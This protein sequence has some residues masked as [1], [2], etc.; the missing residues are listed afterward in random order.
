MKSTTLILLFSILSKI[1]F[2]QINSSSFAPKVDYASGVGTSNPAGV[3][4]VDLDNDGKNDVVSAN[5]GIGSISVYRNT[6]TSTTISL[7]A[8]A[9]YNTLSSTAFIHPADLDGDGKIDLVIS[10]NAGTAFSYFKNTTTTVGTITFANRQDVSALSFTNDFSIADVDGDLKIDLICSNYNSNSFSVFRNTSISGTVSFATRVDFACGSNPSSITVFDADGDTK[11]DVAITNYTSS[12]VSVYRNTTTSIG[13]P[14]FSSSGV[15]VGTGNYPAFIANADLDGDGKM[16]MVT[17]NFVSNNISVIKNTSSTV[18]SIT[19]QASINISSGSGTS[20]PQ[21]ISLTDFDNDRKIDIGVCNSANNNISVFKNISTIGVVSTSSFASQVNFSLNSNPLYIFA[22][23]LNGDG[24]PEILV[25]NYSSNNISILRNQ[26]IATEPTVSASNLVFSNSTST[27]TTLTFTKGNGT[28]RI[29]LAKATSAVNSTPLDSSSY[30]ANDTFGL[31]AQLGTGNYVVYSDTG[32]TINLKGLSP[33][34]NYY[35]AIY[36]YNGTGGFSNYLTSTA[37]TGNILI[38]YAYFSKSSGNLNSLAT[39]G[40]NTDGSGTSPASFGISGTSYYVVNNGS[41]SITGNW[42]ITGTNTSLV[43]GDGTNSGNFVIPTGVSFGTDSFYVNNNF[44][45]TIQGNIFTN[46]AGFNTNSTSQYISNTPQ[47][48]VSANYGNL[49]ISGSTKTILGNVMVKG[50][51]AMFNN[52]DC[53]GHTL[54]LGESTTQTGTLN[55]TSGNIIGNFKRW[56]A[57]S[58]NTGVT[59]VMPVGTTNNYR[60]IQVNYTS[61][62]SSGGTLMATFISGFGG[63]SGFPI[64][65]FTTSPVVQLNKTG[66][67]GYWRLTPADGMAGGVYTITATATG[68]SGINSVSDLRLVRRNLLTTS[69]GLS[70]TSVLGIGTPAIPIIS[71]IGVTNIGGEFAVASDNSINP[72]PAKIISLKASRKDNSVMLNWKTASEENNS[73]FEI[74][75]IIENEWKTIGKVKGNGNSTM[76]NSYSFLDNTIFEKNEQNCRILYRLKQFDFDGDFAY[77]ENVSTNCQT[78]SSNLS[79]SPVPMQSSL[80]IITE[81]IETIEFV[82]IYDI[83]GKEVLKTYNQSNIDVSKLT[84]G[85]YTIKIVTDK[86]IFIEKITK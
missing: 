37:L 8:K 6:S 24:K 10:Y 79:I 11:K 62:P 46:K 85:V 31:G 80:N 58:V 76:V 52:I 43:F 2:A 81:A 44:T 56:F 63:N 71:S 9:D 17:G 75:K 47:N 69:W 54:T 18:G 41:P 64:F 1:T 68:F 25:S 16:D 35:F 3:I 7:A 65:D 51:L 55:R 14:T 66:F 36:E 34:V 50:V 13:S 67:E 21:G 28:R 32:N 30:S 57:T 53:N 78:A 48:I 77:S 33:G 27:S 84:N 40:P 5:L 38:G 20:N 15:T 12:Q 86:N 83:N 4:G 72:L 73:H 74:E 49:V 26:I 29:V 22:S 82:I 70:G 19:F 42:F 60:P 39:W 23:D 59:G 61:A 45:F